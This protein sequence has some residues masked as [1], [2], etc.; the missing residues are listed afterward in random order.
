M[1]SG[2]AWYE[3]IGTLASALYANGMHI[4]FD[5]LQKILNNKGAPYTSAD[6]RPVVCAAAHYWEHKDSLV[7]RAITSAFTRA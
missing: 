1:H 4:R 3:F 5:T 2:A 6:M 7:H